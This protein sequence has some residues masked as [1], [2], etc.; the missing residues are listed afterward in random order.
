MALV[1][2]L[3]I[4]L[5]WLTGAQYAQEYAYYQTFFSGSVSGLGP[6][7]SVRYNGIEV[8]RVAKL[9]FEGK[10][11]TAVEEKGSERQELHFGDADAVVSFG[12][13]QRDGEMPPGNSDSHGRAMVAQLGPLEYL[14]T[15]FDASVSFRLPDSAGK[16]Q[17]QQLEIL[18]A[19]EGR[20]VNGSW[21][22]S[23][24]WNGDQTD[25]GLNFKGSHPDVVR[26]RLHTI[27]LYD[28]SVARPGPE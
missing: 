17:N 12:F 9:N 4:V 11:Q 10:L 21:Q 14:V 7:T 8:G 16:T 28:R 5:L 26:I 24:I 19:E 23:R 27:D 13:P 6:G 22:A 15:G 3:V 18:R 2:G 20:Y 1:L 25:R